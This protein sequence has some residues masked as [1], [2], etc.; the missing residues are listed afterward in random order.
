MDDLPIA[1]PRIAEAVLLRAELGAT[2]ARAWCTTLGWGQWGAAAVAREAARSVTCQFLDEHQASSARR[3]LGADE[4]I[5]CWCAADPPATRCQLVGIPLTMRGDAELARDWLQ[6]GHRL[7]DEHGELLASTDNPRDEWLRGE[8]ERLFGRVKG[9]RHADGVVYRARKTSAPVRYKEFRAEY[10][11]RDGPRLIR[12]V[13]RPGVF[14]HRRLDVGARALL[15]TME[16]EPQQRV[17]D[18]G[19]GAGPVTLAAAGRAAGVRVTG[20]DSNPRAVACLAAGAERNGFDNIAAR[21][22]ATGNSI[23]P[24]HFDV[25]VANPPYYSHGRI[26]QILLCGA[27]RGLRPGGRVWVVT[28]SPEEIAEA[29]EEQFVD[30][31]VQPVRAYWVASAR[32]P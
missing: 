6:Q 22:D 27:A 13:T 32:R 18:L 10:V 19:C 25:A 4:R 14:S 8:M 9:E 26:A 28:K 17:L 20:I 29:L 31:D 15:E 30:V 12:V 5:E 21:V 1:E 3:A 24:A 2:V 11:F 7:L 23:E 16:I